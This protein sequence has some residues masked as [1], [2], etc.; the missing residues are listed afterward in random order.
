MGQEKGIETAARH[1]FIPLGGQRLKTID[2]SIGAV[3]NTVEG[4][5]VT[6][7]IMGVCVTARSIVCCRH[8]VLDLWIQ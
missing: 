8:G 4:D 3:N 6:F 2:L 7:T 1:Q 5:F